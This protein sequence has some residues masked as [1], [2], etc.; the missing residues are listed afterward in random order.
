MK[1]LV[2]SSTYT[3][4]LL[5]AVRELLL[6]CLAGVQVVIR[7]IGGEESISYQPNLPD[8]ANLQNLATLIGSLD[9][10]GENEREQ[11]GFNGMIWVERVASGNMEGYWFS[12]RTGQSPEQTAG[13]ESLP[14]V[15]HKVAVLSRAERAEVLNQ[16]DVGRESV[17]K[18]ILKQLTQRLLK[19]V[20]GIE[21][22]WGTLT[23]MRPT[24]L[25][26]RME[27]RG[28]S[29]EVQ[30]D[31]LSKRYHVRDDK[32]ALLAEVV[33]NQSA[34][35]A[36]LRH[37]PHQVAVYASIPFCPTRCSYCS[38]PGYL[39][40]E[41]REDLALYL[42]AMQEE[43]KA[44]GQLMETVGLTAGSFYL[45]G[46]TPTVLNTDE[47]KTLL[48][49][50][51]D[52][53][54]LEQEVEFTVEAGR[55]D[56][57][58]REKLLCLKELGVN[59]ISIN[60][61]SMNEKTLE[62]IGR[63]HDVDAVRRAFI[64]ARSVH[65]WT[66]NTDIILGLPGEGVDDVKKTLV[67]LAALQPDNLT[68]HVLALKRGSKEW[69]E[70]YSH[71]F[72]A[73]VEAMQKEAASAAAAWGLVPYYL[74]RQRKMAGNLENIGFA[75]PGK[76]CR[77]NIGIMEERQ[78]VLGIGAGAASKILDRGTGTLK[79]IQH[80]FYWKTYLDGWRKEQ[81]LRVR[82]LDKRY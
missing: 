74:Y 9:L 61:Q 81:E 17:E 75:K 14:G 12:E 31:V 39:V 47:L 18:I 66:V 32:I 1:L 51:K 2:Y 10:G 69:E 30:R 4:E 68:V 7:G 29:R 70:G 27:D 58:S 42:A 78:H 35:I 63:A 62:R 44:V 3:T 34:C 36:D 16:P 48:T 52:Y 33:K 46:G 57:F 59:R 54:P 20:W 77:Y 79:N 73:T 60:P 21:V 76:E 72:A 25:V 28:I 56:T 49:A 45:G 80:A 40:D 22:P 64:W 71:T 26:H 55:P 65:G 43:I 24:K 13:Y 53:L 11:T 82:L 37:Y 15:E 23:G 5:Q 41:S 19:A 50:V 38:F 67:G 6:S 8:L